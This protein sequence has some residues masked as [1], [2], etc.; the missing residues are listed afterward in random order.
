MLVK[1]EANGKIEQIRS[2]PES[3]EIID[4]F[5]AKGNWLH[6]P[7]KKLPREPLFTPSGEPIVNEKGKQII[8]SKGTVYPDVTH[9]LYYVKGGKIVERPRL[10]LVERV[11]IEADGKDSFTLNG[12]PRPCVITIDGEPYEITGGV[13]HFS[14]K[15]AGTYRF[16]AGFPFVEGQRFE[17]VAK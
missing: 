10:D 13:L 2:D 5:L 3:Q 7:G 9:D 17:V 8:A 16:E 11:E 12:L 15:D 4:W 14:T 6:I 1:F